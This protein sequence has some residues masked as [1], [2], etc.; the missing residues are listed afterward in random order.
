MI[1]QG[2][3]RYRNLEIIVPILKRH[4]KGISSN[5]LRNRN[6]RKHLVRLCSRTKS[7]NIYQNM[8]GHILGKH[9]SQKPVR[10]PFIESCVFLNLLQTANHI[11]GTCGSTKQVIVPHTKG[12][13]TVILSI[14]MSTPNEKDVIDHQSWLELRYDYPISINTSKFPQI[15]IT[16][17][18]I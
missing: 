13:I 15:F 16:N 7:P 3:C 2:C 10:D 9:T 5:N 17:L 6:T 14:F 18:Q 8:F 11:L 12:S 4:V 1:C